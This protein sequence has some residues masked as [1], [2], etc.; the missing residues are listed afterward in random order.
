MEGEV[1]HPVLITVL[2]GRRSRSTMSSSGKARRSVSTVT[3]FW[4]PSLQQGQGSKAPKLR[5]RGFYGHIRSQVSRTRPSPDHSR[6]AGSCHKPPRHQ[7]A[8]C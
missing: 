8:G 3:T 4:K 2:F 1:T 7:G 6:Q 5:G